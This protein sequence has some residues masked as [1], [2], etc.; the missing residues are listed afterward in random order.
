SC[1][2]GMVVA[3]A[4]REGIRVFYMWLPVQKYVGF[5][6]LPSWVLFLYW[7]IPDVTGVL[8]TVS[9][10]GGVAHLAHVGGVVAGLLLGA[11]LSFS[12]LAEKNS[13]E[14]ADPKTLST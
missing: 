2:M 8:K 7:F 9:E 12:S 10:L 3:V 14:Q 1:L 4:W 11:W 5:F 13:L 6:Y